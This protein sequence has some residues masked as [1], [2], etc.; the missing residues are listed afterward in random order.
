MNSIKVREY[1]R[2]HVLGLV[3]ILGR[4]GRAGSPRLDKADR[5]GEDDAD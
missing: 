5:V 1:L 4:R 3:A 2:R